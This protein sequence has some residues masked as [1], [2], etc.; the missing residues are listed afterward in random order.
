MNSRSGSLQKILLVDDH[1]EARERMRRLLE[2]ALDRKDVVECASFSEA[3]RAIDDGT[4]DIAV[5]DLGLPDGNGEELIRLIVERCPNCYV[6]VSSIHDDS[7]RLIRA[8]SLGARGYLLKEQSEPD[9]IDAIS[10]IPYGRPPLSPPLI[11]KVLEYLRQSRRDRDDVIAPRRP[12]VGGAK[13]S[14]GVTRRNGVAAANV[15]L[16]AREAEIL[17][18]L[19]RGFSRPDIAG[20]LDVSKHTVATHVSNIY[21][22]LNISSRS[23]AAVAARELNLI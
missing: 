14:E 7:N 20:I 15:S 12:A 16:T 23:E 17:A 21:G 3:E 4:F 6:V 19:A 9:L 11:R 18:L 10:G 8:L 2:T 13:Q 22:K 5:L 1:R